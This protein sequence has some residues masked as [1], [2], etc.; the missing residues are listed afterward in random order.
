MNKLVGPES[1]RKAA[2]AA[3]TKPKAMLTM[4]MVSRPLDRQFFPIADRWC[5][6]VRT[7]RRS[8]L[9]GIQ[10]QNSGNVMVE[11]RR[12]LAQSAPA[13]TNGIHPRA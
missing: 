12:F 8:A 3:A 10:D 2:A 4:L 6:F 1:C 5:H 7:A 11:A 9:P 13:R